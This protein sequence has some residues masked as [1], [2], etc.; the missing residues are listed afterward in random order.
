MYFVLVSV[1]FLNPDKIFMP[2]RELHK[3]IYTKSQINEFINYIILNKFS[4]SI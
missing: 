4:Y 1:H 2:K 3:S